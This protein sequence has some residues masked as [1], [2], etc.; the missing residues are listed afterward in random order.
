MQ[1]VEG[2][3]AREYLGILYTFFLF[4]SRARAGEFLSQNGAFGLPFFCKYKDRFPLF[5]FFGVVCPLLR[6]RVHSKFTFFSKK[7]RKTL[8]KS[9][10]ICY[11]KHCDI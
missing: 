9:G 4:L 5:G 2:T 1:I 10:K 3:S 11:N 7:M 6:R 8:F